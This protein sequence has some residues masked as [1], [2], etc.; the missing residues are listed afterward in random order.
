MRLTA[1]NLSGLVL[2]IRVMHYEKD[3]GT[4]R[5]TFHSPEMR[6]AHE[7]WLAFLC[8]SVG[9]IATSYSTGLGGWHAIA[10]QTCRECRSSGGDATSYSSP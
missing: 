5:V 3:A 1:K 8:C 2:G 9:F 6:A 4:S 10:M 7:Q